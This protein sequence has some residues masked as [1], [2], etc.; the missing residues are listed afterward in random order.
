MCLTDEAAQS[1]IE[2]QY[3]RMCG[4][5]RVFISAA[6]FLTCE[7]FMFVVHSSTIVKMVS[8]LLK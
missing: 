6:I 8:D 2:Y 7:P 5:G 1:D 4:Y 3:S